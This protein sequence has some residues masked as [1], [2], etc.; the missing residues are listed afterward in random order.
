VLRDVSFQSSTFYEANYD[1]SPDGRRILGIVTDT[2]N[3]QL[4]VS[5]NWIPELRRRVAEAGEASK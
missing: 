3:F 4:V 2:D 1:V 5:P